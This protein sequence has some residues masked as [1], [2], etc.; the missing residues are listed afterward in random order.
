MNFL[1]A[2]W[3]Q[4]IPDVRSV[5]WWLPH[6]P[7]LRD[8]V[9]WAVLVLNLLVLVWFLYRVLFSG[10]PLNLPDALRRRGASIQDR[11]RQAEQAHGEAQARLRATE[12]RIAN[13][14][15]ELEALAREA[16]REAEDEYRRLVAESERDAERILQQGRQEIEAAA[17]L[18]QKELQRLA[19]SLAIDLAGQR[20]R[21]RLT[22]EQDEAVVGAGLASLAAER[23]Q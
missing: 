22:P 2:L 5:S 12:A 15:A 10:K 4:A 14:P 19:A 7:A 6:N 11:I 13:L 8:T 18:A 21:E 23:P 9:W 16:E 20:L 3:L 17:K 1:V